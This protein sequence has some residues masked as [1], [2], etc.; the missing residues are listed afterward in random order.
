M[1]NFQQFPVFEKYSTHDRREVL[2]AFDFAKKAHTGQKR[3]SG[4]DY[5]SH[6]LAVS[7][8][9]LEHKAVPDL[10]VAGLLHDVIEDTPVGFEEVHHEFG[11]LVA[12]IV[13][14][15]SKSYK[16]SV[17]H[18]DD[19]KRQILHHQFLETI[20][21]PK[22]AMVKVADRLHNMRTLD[23]KKSDRQKVKALETIKMYVPLSSEM[24]LLEISDELS[25]LSQKY[26]SGE[27]FE[28]GLL[29]QKKYKQEIEEKGYHKNALSKCVFQ[30]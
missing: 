9:L 25:Q 23:F 22:A 1:Q 14:T 12:K 7:H 17:V 3:A 24:G 2:Q 27:E 26:L 16:L 4:E 13:N 8:I 5:I 18:E 30:F 15:L 11:F 19:K 6:P 10:V 21:D 28:N 29:L 20:K